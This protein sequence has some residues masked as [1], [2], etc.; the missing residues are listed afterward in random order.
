MQDEV[1]VL[2]ICGTHPS[3]G[4]TQGGTSSADVPS[5]LFEHPRAADPT[6]EL[7]FFLRAENLEVGGAVS[8]ETAL[9]VDAPHQSVDLTHVPHERPNLLELEILRKGA[10]FDLCYALLHGTSRSSHAHHG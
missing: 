5:C 3:V 9:R 4:P 8:L 2:W 1:L 10:L 6:V 7:R